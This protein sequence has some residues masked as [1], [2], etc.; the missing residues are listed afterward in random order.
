MSSSKLSDM[1]RVAMTSLLFFGVASVVPTPMIDNAATGS[2]DAA[3]DTPRP[4]PAAFARLDRLGEELAALR[5]GPAAVGGGGSAAVTEEK[6]AA[7]SLAF[8]SSSSAARVLHEPA[9]DA[10]SSSSSVP[11][12]NIAVMSKYYW[13]NTAENASD[14]VKSMLSCIPRFPRTSPVLNQWFTHGNDMIYFEAY[15]TVFQIWASDARASGSSGWSYAWEHGI[16]YGEMHYFGTNMEFFEEVSP[17]N[18]QSLI[19][20]YGGTNNPP[21]VNATFHHGID[22]FFAELTAQRSLAGFTETGCGDLRASGC[23]A[24]PP[25][26]E[27]AQPRAAQ[28]AATQYKAAAAQRR[29]AGEA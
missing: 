20:E 23:A 15:H 10:V 18:N 6:V 22:E 5:P 11:C 3:S 9:S 12:I 27:D 29:A 13:N 4:R 24:E 26:T 21:I 17:F 19:E 2:L 25:T 1:A 7:P 16:R 8:S 28:F 14:A